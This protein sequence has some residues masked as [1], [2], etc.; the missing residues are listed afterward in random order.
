M[1]NQRIDIFGVPVDAVDFPRALET[2]GKLLEGDHAG[3]I[4]AVNPEKIM[5]ARDDVRL[6]EALNSAK[7]LI[8]DGIGVVWAARWLGLGRLSRVAGAD[9]MP[10]ICE[11]GAAQGR[12]V[13]LYGAS[14]DVNGKVA[15]ILPERY[16]G[17]RV[18]GHQHGYVREPDMPK[19]VADI[20]ASQ[21]EILFVALGSPRQELWM[22][23]YVP[24]LAVKVCQGVGGSFDVIAGKVRRAP[25]LFQ[26][27]HLEW[28]YRLAQEPRRLSR[29]AELPKFAWRVVRMKWSNRVGTA[30]R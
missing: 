2:V 1:D 29:Q 24:E 11:I 16:P 20:N 17:L 26:R 10:A 19:L 12:K 9:L 28:F 14:P 25:P 4:A 8:P 5:R 30:L 23:R 27:M 22:R 3:F 18:V 13:F 21:A 7:L 15:R 6:L